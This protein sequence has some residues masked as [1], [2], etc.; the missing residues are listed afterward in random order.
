MIEISH[1]F[2]IEWESGRE[3]LAIKAS[4]RAVWE[5]GGKYPRETRILR[6]SERDP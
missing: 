5:N 3:V 1:V 6:Q 4:T 2:Q